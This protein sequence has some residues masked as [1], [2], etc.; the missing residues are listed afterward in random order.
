[1]FKIITDIA[2]AIEIF[3]RSKS[4][5][6]EIFKVKNRPIKLVIYLLKNME[7][8]RGFNIRIGCIS[9]AKPAYLK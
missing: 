3:K 9:Q 4:K 2:I 1:M 5:E 7:R 6:I 8:S